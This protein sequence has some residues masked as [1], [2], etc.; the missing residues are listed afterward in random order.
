M[1]HQFY[2]LLTFGV[3]ILITTACT[4]VEDESSVQ[5][6]L[7][8]L[9]YSEELQTALDRALR[10]G[11]G[12]YD[13]GI[14]AAVIVP[15]YEP[16]VGVS[17]RSHPG[18]PLASDMLF[19]VGSVVKSF[20]AALALNL[21]EQG[22]L[23]LD[24]PLST[25][26]PAYPNVDSRITV[27]QLLNHSS[28]VFNVFE[29]PDFPWVSPQ[30]DYDKNWQPEEVIESFVGEPYGP[31]GYAQHYSSTNYL[32]LTKII[33]RS[34]GE[35]VP[36]Q[37][38]RH[39]LEPLVLDHSFI[40]M[41][42]L[43]PAHFT[44]AHPWVDVNLDGELEDFSGT[45]QVWIASMTHPVLF[46]T[47]LDVAK[48]VHALYHEGRVVTDNSLREMLTIPE[49][50]L[51]DPEGGRYGLGVVDFSEILGTNVIGHGGSS[52]GYS[53]AALYLPEYGIS[54]AW[55]INTGE[56]PRLLTDE[57]MGNTWTSLSQVLFEHQDLEPAS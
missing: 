46:A 47:P 38:D 24:Q 15:G 3:F 17:G 35:S 14:S 33:E 40:S 45:S 31:P 37:V 25:W 32:L 28:G 26:L 29:H 54:L 44:V 12:D 9:P 53:A 19:N 7:N 50:T 27:R 4:P 10:D 30:V 21:A 18:V 11:Q 13:L 8:E 57:L 34:V 5:Q 1:I 48:W 56:S 16:W 51:S 42:K 55:S 22:L 49:T 39:F 20:E 36:D 43:P 41:G 6:D 2:A 52:L 23:D